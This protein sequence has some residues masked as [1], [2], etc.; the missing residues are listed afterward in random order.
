M[1]IKNISVFYHFYV[2]DTSVDWVWWIDEQMELLRSTG[3][4]DASTVN[5]CITIP[6]GL[7]NQKNNYTY[8][9]LVINYIKEN[10]SFVNILD[11][12]NVTDQPNLFE[13]Q[14]LARLY[15]HCQKT[16]GYVLYF[17]NKGMTSYGTH[18]PGGL[19]DWREYMHYFNIEKWEDCVAKLDEGYDCCGVNWLVEKNLTNK[20]FTEEQRFL[21]Y[22][23][24]GN[25]WWANNKYIRTLPNPLEIDKYA[26]YE[27]LMSKL[28]TYRYAF[29]SWI[30]TEKT[31]EYCFHLSDTHH[32]FQLYDRSEYD[33]NEEKNILTQDNFMLEIACSSGFTWKDH[34]KFAEWIVRKKQPEVIVDLGVDHGYSTFS[35]ALP[36]IGHVY[37]VDSFEGDKHAGF[38]NTYDYV[39]EKQ[40]QLNLE[41]ITFI[42][43]YFDEI[44]KTWD[45]KIDILHIDGL[46]TYEAIKNDF[47]KWN[48]FVKE[49][50]IILMHDTCVENPSFG[51]RKFFNEIDLPKTNFI[52]SNGLGVVSKNEKLIEEINKTFEDIIEIKYINKNQY[53]N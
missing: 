32:Y 33:P 24:A 6:L 31:K 10:Y 38:R 47:E 29:E 39:V 21:C 18:V 42:K 9:Q 4:A 46:H 53:I 11:V 34:K 51:V 23:F 36:K 48:K 16:D 40:T 35:F 7:V 28:K 41:N 25:F 37:G 45:K 8:D 26:N 15:D 5:M 22:H 3:L 2:P 30:G 12:R 13:G 19:H 52:V 20:A 17:H 43:G 50:G 44:E 49:D 1:Q 27:Y 14:T